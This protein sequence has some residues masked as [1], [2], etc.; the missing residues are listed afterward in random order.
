MKKT[1][2]CVPPPKQKKN[3]V[4]SFCPSQNVEIFLVPSKCVETFLTPASICPVASL[5]NNEASLNSIKKDFDMK[6]CI[7]LS[8]EEENFMK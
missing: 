3:L 7:G 2:S 1:F 5:V 6:Y 8:I 4:K